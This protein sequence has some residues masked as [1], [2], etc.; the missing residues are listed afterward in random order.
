MKWLLLITVAT[1]GVAFACFKRTTKD[2][3]KPTGVIVSPTGAAANDTIIPG[4]FKKRSVYSG[5]ISPYTFQY[6]VGRMYEVRP[7]SSLKPL[8]GAVY[9]TKPFRCSLS[10]L[11]IEQSQHYH[12]RITQGFGLGGQYLAIAA[13]LKGNQMI[14]FTMYDDVVASI[15]QISDSTFRAVVAWAKKNPRVD[16]AQRRVWITEV[17]RTRRTW[18][19]F[20]TVN[21]SVTAQ[22]G[23]LVGVN[24]TV[25]RRH[26][27]DNQDFV[28]GYYTCDIDEFTKKATEKSLLPVSLHEIWE[29]CL[30]TAPISRITQ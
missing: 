22:I 9:P 18:V 25:Y 30:Y 8:L 19:E 5:A 24:G 27:K 13:N 15:G 14:D 10:L 26:E 29:H 4:E 12:S 7:D 21:V 23:E 2:T 11:T 28:L 6:A 1:V 20:D 3:L 16:P 17:V